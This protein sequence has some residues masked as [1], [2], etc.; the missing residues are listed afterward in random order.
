MDVAFAVSQER[1]VEDPASMES[2]EAFS[3]QVGAGA[4]GGGA[5]TV[6]VATQEFEPKAPTAV[7]V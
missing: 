2:A 1:V 6:I 3:T 4:G 7:P 5:V